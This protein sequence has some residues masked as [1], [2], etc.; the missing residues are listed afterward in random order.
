[1]NQTQ[2]VIHVAAELGRR[3]LVHAKGSPGQILAVGLAA[4]LAIT[5]AGIGLGIYK[6]GREGLPFARNLIT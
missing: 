3:I 4:A 6:A 2:D 1:M 5:A